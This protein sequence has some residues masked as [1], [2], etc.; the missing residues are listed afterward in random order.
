M[1]EHIFQRQVIPLTLTMVTCAVL[2]GVVAME[3]LVLNALT[4]NDISLI[5]RPVDILVGL[6]IY[7][8][9][10]IDFAI[11]IGRLM[12]SYGG[13]KNRVAIEIGTALGNALGTM[14]ILSIWT[15]F[16]EVEWLLALMIF[17]ASLVL[18]RMAEDGLEHAKAQDGRYPA[19]FRKMVTL[20]EWG[21]GALNKKIA[22]M[23]RYIIPSHKIR[24]EARTTFF[25]LVGFSFTIPFIL[26]LDD[27][28]GYVPLFDVIN[29]FGFAIGVFVGH[30]LLNIALYIQPAKTIHAVKNPIV[31][32]VG[33]VV[34][35]GLAGWGFYE[36]VHLF[37]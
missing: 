30:M 6:T 17:I 13:W 10:S 5:I 33:S 8:K 23:L 28:A 32:F 18:L 1:K 9:T 20:F 35:V 16:K 7:L 29:V 36:V 14:I 4:D 19:W 15:F 2:V 3:I 22:P 31:S 21:L 12:D 25:A 27:F 11:F 37:Y 34:F 26:G 24:T